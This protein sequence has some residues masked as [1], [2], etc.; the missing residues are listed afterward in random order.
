MFNQDHT[1][2]D[3]RNFLRQAQPGGAPEAYTLMTAPPLPATLNDNGVTLKEA[4]LLNAER[5]SVACCSQGGIELGMAALAVLHIPSHRQRVVQGAHERVTCV[6]ACKQA[7]LIQ[8]QARRGS[9]ARGQA[10]PFHRAP[11]L[12]H[13]VAPVAL[14]IAHLRRGLPEEAP[15]GLHQSGTPAGGGEGA[16]QGRG[17]QV[18]EGWPTCRQA[19]GQARSR[20]GPAWPTSSS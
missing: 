20:P 6:C 11:R 14:E 18:K 8:L 1:V 13:T 2:G 3:I 10:S 4:G 15:P 7:R 17:G 9:D 16:M 5:Y 12:G 19:R